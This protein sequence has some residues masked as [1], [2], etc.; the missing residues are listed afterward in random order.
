M[1]VVDL[2][3]KAEEVGQDIQDELLGAEPEEPGAQSG[4]QFAFPAIAR[5]ASL[6]IKTAADPAYSIYS[7]WWDNKY[8]KAAVRN[9]TATWGWQHLQKH[10]VSLAMLQKTTKVVVNPTRLND[11]APRGVISAHCVGPTVCPTWVRQVG[12]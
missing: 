9:G 1:P 12:G 11:G 2:I 10:N 5:R 6:P 4:G 3:E 8:I 7:Q